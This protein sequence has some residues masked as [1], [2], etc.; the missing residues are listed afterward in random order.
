MLTQWHFLHEERMSLKRNNPMDHAV[1]NFIFFFSKKITV[2][3]S[4][5]LTRMW[6]FKTTV[7]KFYSQRFVFKK[8]LLHQKNVTVVIPLAFLITFWSVKS[9][10]HWTICKIQ[11]E[12]M[13]PVRQFLTKK[14]HYQTDN[15]HTS[16]RKK[17]IPI[18]TWLK[19]SKTKQ[20]IQSVSWVIIAS[21]T[22]L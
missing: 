7:K 15:H 5:L 19:T 10:F 6:N 21:T 8:T 1:T 17:S 11:Y 13:A 9:P 20:H 2:Y 18:L 4:N 16:K 22:L 3:A 14:E 12:N